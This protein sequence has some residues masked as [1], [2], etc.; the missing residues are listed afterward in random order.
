MEP[1]SL[2]WVGSPCGLHGPYIFYKAFQFHLEGKPRILSLGDFFFVRC[3]PKDPICIAELQLLWEER[4]S[5]QLLS[6]SKLYFLPEDTPQGRNSD[7][8]EDEV[9]AVSEKVIVKLEDLVK[10]VHSDF[11]KWRCGLQAGSVKTSALGRNGQKEALLKYRQSTLNS[12]LNF[13]DVLKEKADL[14]EDEEETNVI[15]LSYPQYCRYRSMLKRI[16][17]KPSSILTDQFALALGGIAVVSKNPQI[18]YCRDTFD[19]PTLIENESICDEFAPNLK[20]RPR[21][22]KPCPQRRD[23]FSGVKDSNNNS[24]GKAVAKVKCEARSA[25]SKPKNNHNNCKKVS[26]E[27]K[28]KVAIGEECRADEQAFLVALYKYMKERKTPIERIPYLGFKQINLWTM[29]QAAQKLGG[30][31][32]ITA[33]RQWKHIYDELGGNP[34]STS[35]ATCTRRHYER[36]IL[37]YERFIKGEEDKPLP[38]IKPR[39]QENSSQENENKTK[40]SGPK[41]VKHE[42]PKSKK[43]KENAPKPQ[44]SSEVSS[45]PEKEQETLNQ[46]SIT[47]PLPAA[48]VKKKMEGYQ[49][50]AARPL[51]SRADPEKDND[52][53]Q[54]A[55]S[56][57]VAEK[58]AEKEPAPPLPSAPAAPERGP[59]LV[60]GA[61]KQ[62]L[63][64]PSAL[65]DSKQDPQPCCFTESPE[66]ELQEA[67]FPGFSTTQPPLANQSEL[68]DDKLPAMADYIANC[69][70]KVDQLGSDDIHNALKQTP[71]VLVVQSFDMFKDKDL[72]GPMNE[73]HGL[74]YTP[75]LYSRGNPGI[76]SPLAKKKLLSQVSGA[77]LSSSYPYGSPPPLISKKK[78]MARDDLCS[79][80]SQAHHGQ[81]TDHMAVSRPSVI[82]HVQ[83]FRS[84]PAEERKSISDIFKHDKLGRS[85]PHR[86]SFS[87][88]HL[89]PL[90]DSYVLKQDIQ[91]GKE[92]LLEKR[93]LP[94]SH[95]PS[96]L[97]D[98]YSSPHLHSLYRHTEHHLHNEQ[99]SK[100]AC[101]DM[102]REAENSVFPSHK[103]QE[104][105]HVNY[106]ASLHLQDKKAAAV[107]E[108]PTDDQPTDL[109]LP[110][111]LHKPTGK[112]L[113]LAHAAPGPQES[114]GVSQ[115]Q[116]MN[117]QTRDCHPKACRV[118]PMTMSAPK[119]YAESLSRSGKPQHGR[120]ENF[121][122]IEGMVHPVLQRKASPQNIGAARPIKRSLEDLDLVIAG[123][124]ARAVSP[125]DASKEACGKEKAA[126]EPESDGSKAAPGG[127]SGGAPEGHKLPLS[128]PIFPGLYSGSLCG[129][130]LNSRLPAGY[131]HSL[132]YLK[133]QTVLSPL[134][135]PLAF[136]SLVMQRGIFTS[137]TNSQ[138]LYRH[139]AAATPVG[140]S[141]GDLLHNSIYP[142]AA[143]NPQAAFPSSQLSSVHPS[144]KL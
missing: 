50:F 3:T 55:N 99:T 107:A 17:D 7:H 118:S 72:T 141:Y 113:G 47:E 69:T 97:A 56:E 44:E 8:G 57:K 91:E 38:P 31:E 110:K 136:H 67:P 80:L 132:Q 18:L 92:K 112:V 14:G 27:E 93:S 62:S 129:S 106:L 65:V 12:G 79:G 94:H 42:I 41:R 28:P 83:S 33:R 68:E 53:D 26:N 49:D 108:A 86:C 48:D 13:K 125:L 30:Y 45:E 114:K 122:K 77:S 105:L 73:N 37:P 36:L 71:K 74:N 43:E 15:V 22:K 34:G 142:L 109:S 60:P 5:R 103:H 127:H 10:W 40:V 98:F 52:T 102:Y 75:L 117:S 139:L 59:A 128:S 58:V 84:K 24:D 64:S 85:D 29:F 35:A 90:A 16:Q 23:S 2:Q 89:S 76:M 104:K 46:K 133:N 143:I 66:S 54:G 32:T 19:H 119:K 39:K 20:G 61:G 11:S 82:Q 63:T 111:N 121:R 130:G 126:S 144:T 87:K 70:V 4:T 21:K 78:L 134:M 96:F 101:R 137:P 120:L 51:G 138:Q 25:L 140:S 124:K 88:H 116:V 6:S 123:K 100:Y 9:I 135:Q 115:F 95:M 81:G 131:S 1:N